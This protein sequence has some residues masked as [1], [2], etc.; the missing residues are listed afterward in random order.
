MH[1]IT[2]MIVEKII[3]KY[4]LEE[5]VPEGNIRHKQEKKSFVKKDNF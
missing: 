4:T 2:E 5:W 1:V 3:E